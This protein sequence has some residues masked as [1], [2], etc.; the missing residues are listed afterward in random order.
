MRKVAGME[1][2]RVIRLTHQNGKASKKRLN[3]LLKYGWAEVSY[4][5]S[6]LLITRPE[7][8]ETNFDKYEAWEGFDEFLNQ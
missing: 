3:D 4:S 5:H 7:A 8:T 2:E 1:M 6:L